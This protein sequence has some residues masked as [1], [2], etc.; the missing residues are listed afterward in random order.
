MGTIQQRIRRIREEQNLSIEEFGQ[1]MGTFTRTIIHIESEYKPQNTLYLISNQKILL[2]V[3][4]TK[5][6]M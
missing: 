4:L 5:I 1:M 3:F 6:K 2:K